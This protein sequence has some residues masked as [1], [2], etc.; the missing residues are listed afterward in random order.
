[1]R[2]IERWPFVSVAPAFSRSLFLV[3]AAGSGVANSVQPILIHCVD[4]P[5]PRRSGGGRKITRASAVLPSR[6]GVA[7]GVNKNWLN[8]AGH[9]MPAG[10]APKLEREGRRTPPNTT[11]DKRRIHRSFNRFRY[12]TYTFVIAST[13]SNTM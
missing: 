4:D 12:F 9:P 7:G 1:M 11:M 13:A 6:Y 5:T 2:W 3:R 8:V 10:L